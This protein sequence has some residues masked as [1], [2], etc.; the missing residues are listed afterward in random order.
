MIVRTALDVLVLLSF[1][2]LYLGYSFAF[3][4][5]IPLEKGE[6]EERMR[7]LGLRG[8]D[9]VLFRFLL[10]VFVLCFVIYC[11]FSGFGVFEC[12]CFWSGVWW[13]AI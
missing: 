2:S 6:I 3:P 4:L 1:L 9:P 11:G 13:G 12:V 8:L 10:M 7:P 5:T